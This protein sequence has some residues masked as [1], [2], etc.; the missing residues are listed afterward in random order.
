MVSNADRLREL[1]DRFW[2]QGDRNAGRDVMA[3]DIVWIGLDGVGLG[4][5]HSGRREVSEFFAEWLEAW[6]DYSN[7]VEIFELTPDLLVTQSF[8]RGRGKSSGIEFEAELGQIWQFRDGRVVR[9][10]MFRTLE[11]ARRHAEALLRR[12]AR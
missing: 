5:N 2:D 1:F 3:D 6:E 12:D 4:G 7:Q 11:E 9:Q 8:F 10:E